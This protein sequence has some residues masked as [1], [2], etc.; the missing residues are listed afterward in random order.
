MLKRGRLIKMKT[1]NKCNGNL[2]KLE[3][4]V[5]DTDK[6]TTG[7]KC[8]DCGEYYF[9]QAESKAIYEDLSQKETPALNI[10]QKIVKLSKDRLGI[11][12]NKDVI[13][14]I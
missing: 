13:R 12:L 8:K 9:D 5:E 10:K 14:C 4:H 11:Y 6:T 7:W 1:C 2:E 3:V